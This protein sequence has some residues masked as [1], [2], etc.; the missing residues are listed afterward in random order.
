MLLIYHILDLSLY[1]YKNYLITNNLLHMRIKSVHKFLLLTLLAVLELIIVY[2]SPL[3]K[4]ATAFSIL[5]IPILVFAIS[6]NNSYKVNLIYSLVSHL[7]IGCIDNLIWNAIHSFAKIFNTNLTYIQSGLIMQILSLVFWLS[8]TYHLNKKYLSY[9][10][11]RQTHFFVFIALASLFNSGVYQLFLACIYSAN[12]AG[13][14]NIPLIKWLIFLFG[15]ALIGE[16]IYILFLYHQKTHYSIVNDFTQEYLDMEKAHFRDIQERDQ[17]MRKFRHD[18][19]GHL[20]TINGY[21]MENNQDKLT[22][23]L[24]TLT[25]AFSSATPKYRTG[26]TMI[27]SILNQKTEL[28]ESHQIS[29]TLT[30]NLSDLNIYDDFDLCTIFSNAIENAIEACMQI[31]EAS[32]RF[33]EIRLRSSED[34]LALEIANS[35][36]ERVKIK[37]NKIATNKSDKTNHGFGLVQIAQIVTNLSGELYLDCD[38]TTFKIMIRLKRGE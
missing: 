24:H 8:I 3:P 38:D 14:T 13:Y 25:D 1:L 7:L 17:D 26:N 23:Y 34:I 33:I 29:L 9:V 30:D 32:M 15:L 35:V 4:I 6:L 16:L 11:K 27:D 31:P 12:F 10:Y 18:I 20:T 5:L 36:K 37:R 21:L 22:Q 2:L 19:Q 28:I